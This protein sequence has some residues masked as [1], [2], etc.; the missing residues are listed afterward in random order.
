M[1]TQTHTNHRQILELSLLEVQFHLEIQRRWQK[2][3]CQILLLCLDEKQ[4]REGLG[5]EVI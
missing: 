2:E 4:I 5:F 1:K 3:W